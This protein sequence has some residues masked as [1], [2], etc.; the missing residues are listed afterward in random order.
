MVIDAP[1][2]L[3]LVFGV[4][5]AENDFYRLQEVSSYNKN[6]KL[7]EDNNVSEMII[8]KTIIIDDVECVMSVLEGLSGKR[9][10][11]IETVKKYICTERNTKFY[12]DK[13]LRSK[14]NRDPDA[15]YLWLDTGYRDWNNN[16][17]FISLLNNGQDYKGHY[18]GTAQD[19]ANCIRNFFPAY[20]KDININY[21]RF[22]NKYKQKA[23]KRDYEYIIDENWYLLSRNNYE[24]GLN[25][26]L[27]MQVQQSGGVWE[28]DNK[29]VVEETR[30]IVPETE[31]K[32][33]KC[34]EEITV[35]LLLDLLQEREQYIQELLESLEKNKLERDEETKKLIG[36]I[37]VQSEIIKERTDAL[38]NIRIFTEEESTAQFQRDMAKECRERAKVGHNLLKNGR[39][40]IMVLGTTNLSAEVMRGIVI[41]EYG[42]DE[43]DFEY[44]TDY[45]KVVH[46]SGRIINSTKY[47]AIIFGCCPHSVTGKGKWS[48][49]I[50][51]CKQEKEIYT[52]D[53]R[54]ISGNLK[55][56]KASFR[57]ALNEVCERMSKSA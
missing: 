57:N 39:K 42:F 26:T 6:I 13:K 36:T 40:K 56:T 7:K 34:E 44:E 27:E 49:L 41:K 10:S 28:S 54:N 4:W 25:R 21:A 37:K 52:V 5:E 55:V 29:K 32:M 2:A 51:R 46:A 35:S 3:T 47:R 17:I 38:T 50:E 45:Q 15:L 33:N 24:D 18:V 43:G 30:K 9:I 14:V 53:A 19:L 11:G 16:A 8:E 31:D 12:I 22:L 48:G 20:R 1:N 23:E